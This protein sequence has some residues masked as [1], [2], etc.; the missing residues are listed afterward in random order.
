MIKAKWRIDWRSLQGVG[1]W[2]NV[3]VKGL[4]L[5]CSSVWSLLC[6]C[7]ALLLAK[8][9]TATTASL[10]IWGSQCMGRGWGAETGSMLRKDLWKPFQEPRSCDLEELAKKVIKVK[11]L[12]VFQDIEKCEKYKK[13][14][15]GT[16]CERLWWI[17]FI[18]YHILA[19]ALA[20]CSLFLT[21]SR[22]TVKKKNHVTMEKVVEHIQ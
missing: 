13:M 3:W 10:L 16:A 12:D 20:S 11:E 19:L 4:W 17:F 18:S 14:A 2:D 6:L 5:L 1:Y 22:P 15:P 7:A 21:I 8:L 9:R